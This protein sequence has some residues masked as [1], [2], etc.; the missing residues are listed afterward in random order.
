[1]N[2]DILI[3]AI[4]ALV[5]AYRLYSTLGAVDDDEAM[6]VKKGSENSNVIDLNA[7]E[8]EVEQEVVVDKEEQR[9]IDGLG[10]SSKKAVEKIKETDQ[11]FQ[12]KNFLLGA[13]KAFEIIISSFVKGD[14]KAISSLTTK[15]MSNKFFAEL[16]SL[17]K[18]N[19]NIDINIV[20]I[21]RN[22]IDTVEINKN[23]VKISVK[24]TSEQI[25][26][27]TDKNDKVVSGNKDHIE[28]IDDV[29]T[30]EKDIKS[31]NNIWMLS[32]TES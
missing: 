11:K 23:I 7:E 29:W 26:V 16:E 21:I 32:N 15:E 25:T 14:K 10:D 18:L 12:L 28:E 19:R 9:I 8:Y 24:L 5:V 20:A 3:F 1:M 30:F 17:K 27:V 6:L 2:V 13:E 22:V 4:I 31:K